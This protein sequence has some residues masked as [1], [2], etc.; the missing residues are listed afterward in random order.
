M[1]M[2]KYEGGK[3]PGPLSATRPHERVSDKYNFVHTADI[4]ASMKKHG[5]EVSRYAYNKAKS[6]DGYQRH[7]VEFLNDKKQFNIVGDERP[8]L[9]LINSHDATTAARLEYGFIRLACTNGLVVP[10][11]V[12]HDYS[13]RHLKVDETEVAN[14]LEDIV[15]G[16]AQAQ[17]RMKEFKK[18]QLNNSQVMMFAKAAVEIRKRYYTTELVLES[19]VEAKRNEDKSQDLWTVYNRIQ[20]NVTSG[21]ARQILVN[22]S[23]DKKMERRLL[24]I[25]SIKNDIEINK[26]LWSVMENFAHGKSKRVSQLI[27]VN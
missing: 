26:A 2:I 24:P 11:G 9:M 12:N 18:I 27:S 1:Q 10:V 5:W 20:E 3:L 7:C 16:L 13:F 14:F 21:G 8:R 23:D 4:I 25:T 17:S 6:R 19:T 15:Q 22:S